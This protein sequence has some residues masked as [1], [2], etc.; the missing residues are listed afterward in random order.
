MKNAYLMKVFVPNRE[1][2]ADILDALAGVQCNIE[3]EVMSPQPVVK[4]QASASNGGGKLHKRQPRA[5]YNRVSK[6][7][8]TILSAI[9]EGSNE[10]SALKQALVKAGMSEHSLS[11]GLAALYKAGKI[12]RESREIPYGEGEGVAGRGYRYSLA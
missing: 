7:N 11:T 4:P 10:A 6:V 9:G 3:I 8:E 1:V 2:V 5:A 12:H